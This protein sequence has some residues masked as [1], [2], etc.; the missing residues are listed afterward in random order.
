[1]TKNAFPNGSRS[2]VR[3]KTAR[4]VLLL[5]AA[6]SFTAS[7]ARAQA[8]PAAEASPIS[9]GFSIPSVGGSLQWAVS[10][11]SSFDW[12][13]YSKSGATGG[14]SVSGDVAYLS[15]SKYHPFS[16]VLAAGNTWGWT[17]QPSYRFASLGL[18]QLIN[19]GRWNFTLSDNVSYL[20]Q[21]A[22][23]NLSGVPGVGDLGVAPIQIGPDGGQGLLTN[24]SP[25]VSNAAGGSVLRQ[26]TGKTA[27]NASGS[28][29]ILRFVDSSNGG[30]GLE[31]DTVTGSAGI[32]HRLNARNTFGGNYAY[33]SYKFLN[34]LNLGFP[35]S[36]F[37]SQTASFTYSHQVSRRLSFNVAAG[38]EWTKINYAQNPVTVNAYADVSVHYA[39]R[40]GHMLGAYVRSTNSGFGVVGGS[41][42][43]SVTFTATRLHREVWSTTASV[44][45][46]HTS[47]LPTPNAIAYD[48]KTLV[49]GFQVSR[50]LSHSLSA[51][52]SFTVEHQTHASTFGTVNLFD[53]NNNILAF[54]ITYSPVSR[55]FA[56]P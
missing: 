8:L 52:T 27:F 29:S 46:T 2:N 6:M 1:M 15:E 12:G 4:K 33:S 44:G 11:S 23:S 10:A 37:T 25:Q 19:V 51:F 43:D 35:Q 21:T 7:A 56:R 40:F 22:T 34:N 54:G 9:T 49:A 38:P 20:P 41:L 36:N 26:I 30:L 45:W 50:A 55:R 53:G 28:Y 31:G 24:Y 14:T 47:S 3:R 17:K 13:Y 42:S 39:T 48:V 5:I 18:S 16:M 32:T